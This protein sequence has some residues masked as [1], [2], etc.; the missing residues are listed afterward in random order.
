M[1]QPAQARAWWADVED[2]RERIEHRRAHERQARAGAPAPRPRRAAAIADGA[3]SSAVRA[4]AT[5]HGA[6][7]ATLRGVREVRPGRHLTVVRSL[8]GPTGGT[9]AGSLARRRPTGVARGVARQM[10]PRP[11]MLA[12]WA[13]ALG[14]ALVLAAILSAHA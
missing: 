1:P 11:D 14:F 6:E 4:P 12:A 13:V 10:G 7:P 5:P 9:A 8:A 2:V 3:G